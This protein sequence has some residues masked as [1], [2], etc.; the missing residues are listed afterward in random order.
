MTDK[1]GSTTL[2]VTNKKQGKMRLR[3]TITL[4]RPTLLTINWKKYF[5]FNIKPEE[6][7]K[8]SK[9]SRVPYLG[10]DLAILVKIF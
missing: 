4:I 1:T 6:R 8:N 9:P 5:N 10:L 2:L 7:L 3:D